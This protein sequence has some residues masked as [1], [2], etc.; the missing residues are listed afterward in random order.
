MRSTYDAIIVGAGIVGATCA[1]ECAHAGMIVAIIEGD[2][3]GGGATAA[4]M[5]HIVVMDDS[6]AQ[7]ALTRYSQQLWRELS[8]QLPPDVEYK[9]TGTIWIAADSS[10]MSEIFR[11]HALYEANDLSVQV[12]DQPSLRDA[13]PNLCPD[14]AGGLLVP[15]DAVLYPPCAARY[16]LLEAAKAG[17]I[18]VERRAVTMGRGRVMLNDGTTLASPCVVNAAGTMATDLTPG[19]NIRKRK[20]H[21]IIT[22]RAPEFVHHQL[23]EVGYLRSAGSSSGDSV[24]FNVQ[25]RKTG[26]ILIG[27]SRQYDAKEKQ[28]DFPVLLEMMQRVQ[29]YLP[30]VKELPVIRA[31]TGFRAATPDKLPL[32]GPH[33][34][35]S[36]LLLATGHEGLGI[37]TSLATAK[38]LV[39]HL[40][41]SAAAISP[42]PYLP[43]RMLLESQHV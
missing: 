39:H 1:M 31:W 30:G 33:P 12:L 18:I 26:Q 29:Q 15:F 22:D 23:V 14:L 35:D 43:S 6:P 20:G 38:L 3:I 42:E 24:A 34:D 37:T 9:E 36:T 8:P 27:S 7:L 41:G 13:E 16:F 2:V 28:I 4:G 10:E 21:L 11:K 25:P 32:I 40:T 17:A 5:G 19:L